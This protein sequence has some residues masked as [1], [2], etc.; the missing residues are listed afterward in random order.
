MVTLQAKRLRSIE[1][2]PRHA[3]WLTG[4]RAPRRENWQAGK[5]APRPADRQAVEEGYADELISALKKLAKQNYGEVAPSPLLVALEDS[6]PTL[7][8]RIDA[9]TKLSG[10]RN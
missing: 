5:R 9:I 1:R 4:K 7:S 8:Q 2:A 6:H 10:S 3:G